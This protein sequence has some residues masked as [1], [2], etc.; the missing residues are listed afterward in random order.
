MRHRRA[1]VIDRAVAVLDEHG[2]AELSM[3]RLAGELGVRASALYHH[4]ANKEELLAAVADEVLERGRQASEIVT[5]ESELRLA[6]VELRGA[7]LAHRDGAALISQVYAAGGARAPEVRMTGA[8]SRAGASPE[9]AR[10]GA[11]TLVRFV[12]GHVA[13]DQAR[14]GSDAGTADEFAVG[15][16][17]ILDGL[18][19]RFTRGSGG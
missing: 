1:D 17:L 10:V 11:R 12:L 9:L 5:W 19:R 3:R 2:L 13:D 16:G 14:A 15:L 4:V 8:L 7:M 6:C 18:D